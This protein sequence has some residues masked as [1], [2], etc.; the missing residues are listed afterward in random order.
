MTRLT[1]F[2]LSLSGAIWV[3]G[4]GATPPRSGPTQPAIEGVP[5]PFISVLIQPGLT[6]AQLRAVGERMEIE[7]RS[8][9]PL[10]AAWSRLSASLEDRLADALPQGARAQPLEGLGLDPQQPVRITVAAPGGR[11]AG[12]WLIRR[13]TASEI[14]PGDGP[15]EGRIWHARVEAQLSSKRLLTEALDT[16]AG[17]LGL[18]HREAVGA[19]GGADGAKGLFAAWDPDS[20]LEITVRATADGRVLADVWVRTGPRNVTQT[21]RWLAQTTPW[22][23]GPFEAWPLSAAVYFAGLGRFETTLAAAR[24]GRLPLDSAELKA[25]GEVVAECTIRWGRLAQGATRVDFAARAREGIPQVRAR[26]RLTPGGA[27][28]WR[29]ALT[30]LPSGAFRAAPAGYRVGLG[31]PAVLADVSRGW[32]QT[33]TRCG[34]SSMPALAAA[35]LTWLPTLARPDTLPLPPSPIGW[36]VEGVDGIAAAVLG[37]ASVEGESTPMLAGLVRGAR[38]QLGDGPEAGAPLGDSADTGPLSSD[39][40]V[41]TWWRLGGL[42]PVTMARVERGERHFLL[43]GIGG[44]ALQSMLPT[45]LDA[46]DGLFLEGWLNPG[47]L[48]AGLVDGGRAGPGI[49]ALRAVG[50]RFGRLL[51]RG[52]ICDGL[53]Q[54]TAAFTG[55]LAPTDRLGCHPAEVRAPI[56][57]RPRLAK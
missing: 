9:G 36:P 48:A 39:G 28:V 2:C 12:R 16:L 41:G 6:L 10:G 47:E 13:L 50:R 55:E 24:A 14:Q 30:P 26:V 37:A 21:Q 56:L 23:A 51:L 7:G 5:D 49:D 29:Q 52:E 4:C 20:G 42:L 35:G 34:A 1:P 18:Q 38:V 15:W 27:F 3:V 40:N 22:P 45:A 53:P 8:L 31:L 57:D 43:F 25:I 54:F 44:D 33:H 19:L 46:A 11:R 17:R 32:W